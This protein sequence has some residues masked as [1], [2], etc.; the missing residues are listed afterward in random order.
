M[1]GFL[2]AA[3]LSDLVIPRRL[4]F[5]ASATPTGVLGYASLD[6]DT[7]S[8]SW[9]LGVGKGSD[10]RKEC[11]LAGLRVEAAGSGNVY[12][13]NGRFLLEVDSDDLRV[14]IVDVPVVLLGT[15]RRGDGRRRGSLERSDRSEERRLTK[16]G[17]SWE[18]T[19]IN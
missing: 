6:E 11:F 8:T 5:H 9:G 4:P 19:S 16:A 1:L 13:R 7:F 18:A 14:D 3:L 17:R 12:E 15:R 2:F 10:W